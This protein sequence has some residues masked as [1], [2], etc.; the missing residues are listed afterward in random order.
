MRLRMKKIKFET[1]QLITMGILAV[2]FVTCFISFLLDITQIRYYYEIFGILVIYV[3][4]VFVISQIKSEPL[5]L[6]CQSLL[7]VS[8]FFVL[9][10]KL[11]ILCFD[12]IPY[13]GDS[14]LAKADKLISFGFAPVLWAER[15]VNPVTLRIFSFSYAVFIPYLYFSIFISLLGRPLKERRVFITAFSITYA[16]SF[17]GYL[18]V[19]AKGPIVYYANEFLNPLINGGYFHKLIVDTIDKCGGPHGAFPSL[20][21]GATW[22]ICYFDL[23]YNRIR[24]LLYVPLV[25]FISCATI[26][27][28]YHFV[29][30]LAAG[31]IIASF[32]VHSAGKIGLKPGLKNLK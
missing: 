3:L 18:F 5:N 19:P 28:R 29:I 14:V 6:L 32:A 13:N 23:K 16:I 11:G 31:F 10:L 17:L 30:D 26:L 25:L 8:V 4:A 2:I 12:V 21:I 1:Y 15:F 22:F 20:H 27:L 24:G 9:Y 7:T